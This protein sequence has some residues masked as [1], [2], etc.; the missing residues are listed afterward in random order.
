VGWFERLP[1][2]FAALRQGQINWQQ[3]SVICRAMEE[4]TKTKLDPAQVELAL[5]SA[6]QQVD[7]QTL[8]MLWQQMRYQGDQEAGLEAEEEQRRNRWLRLWQ[9]WKGS[10]R[11][12]GELDPEGGTALKTVLQGLMKKQPK[13]DQRT[14]TQRRAD[15]VVEMAWCC[16]EAGDL[17]E[18]GGEKPHLTLISDIS[19]LRLEPGSRLAELDWGPLV[20]GESARRIACDAA[21]TPVIVH[22]NGEVLY[23][24]N[25]SRSLPP[26]MH[27]AL[28]LRDRHCQTPG[29]SMPPERCEA[30]HIRHVR[31]EALRSPRGGA[32]PPPSGCR[33]SLT[34]LRAA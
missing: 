24:G 2:T 33:S 1:R 19:T 20:T 16:L 31:R 30:H 17:P 18:Q 6:A 3:V 4:V 21:I 29:C 5:V 26:R 32:R 9:T 27:K 34:K 25:S 8:L 7:A 14:P 15:A 10:Y 23:V 22:S 11:L 13:D 12:E 28:K